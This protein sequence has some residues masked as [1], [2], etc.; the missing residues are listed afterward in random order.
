MEPV[1]TE[2]QATVAS[3]KG[4][5]PAVAEAVNKL[6]AAVTAATN[7]GSMS[8]EDKDAIT[9]ANDELKAALQ[10]ISDAVADANDGTDEAA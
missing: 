10:G 5:I 6:E 8:Q 9:A 3:I 4:A 7:N 1:V 2:L